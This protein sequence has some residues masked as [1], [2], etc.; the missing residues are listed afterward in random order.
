VPKPKHRIQIRHETALVWLEKDCKYRVSCQKEYGNGSGY[1]GGVKG[2]ADAIAKVR[3]MIEG[4]EGFDSI[5]N[6][7]GDKVTE[8]NTEYI[9]D[10]DVTLVE[11]LHNQKGLKAFFG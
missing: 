4:W 2:R 7:Y 6:R 1:G 5:L 8:R 3:G 11:I 10:T 9:T